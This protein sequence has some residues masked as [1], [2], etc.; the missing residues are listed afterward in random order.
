[1]GPVLVRRILA[2]F[3]SVA[4]VKKV[5]SEDLE[6]VKGI[7]EA[8]AKVIVNFYKIKYNRI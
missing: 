4:G 6:K 5:R 2:R 3:G 7:S 8:L 1:V